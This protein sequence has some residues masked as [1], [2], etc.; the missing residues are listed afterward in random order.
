MI[1]FSNID[2][3]YKSLREE[4]LHVTDQVLTSGNVVDGDF[5][6][7]FE[8]WLA[9]KNHAKHAITCTSGTVALEIIAKYT[10]ELICNAINRSPTIIIP[11]ITYPATANAF[12]NAGWD[13][14]F[15]DVDQYGLIKPETIPT[16]SSHYMPYYM[17]VL[18]GLYGSSVECK[19]KGDDDLVIEDA[20]QHWLSNDCQR[21]GI[22]SAISFDPT[23]NFGNYGN[24]G[25]IVTN[26]GFLSEYAHAYRNNGKPT[27]NYIGSNLRMSEVDCAQL[28]IKSKYIDEW[29]QRRK[30]I[31]RYWMTEF[32][33]QGLNVLI[34]ENHFDKH[35][36]HKF[37]I[38]CN[39]RDN[40][41][42]KLHA[43]GIQTK[44]HYDTP[45]FKL[46]SFQHYPNPG[47]FST[48]DMLSK[49]VLSLPCYPEL[50]DSE[51]EYIAES[52]IKF[53]PSKKNNIYYD[54][55]KTRL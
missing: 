49:S 45:V 39:N 11:S 46:G 10:K 43:A 30:D 33:E 15:A 5:T 28:M 52:V 22:S 36:Y 47:M 44:V 32:K 6:K 53:N 29:Q 31:F 8:K 50:T 16:N 7:Q 12:A 42:K 9:A 27:N 40:M 38:S 21:C 48:A 55:V 37:V 51:I 25:A 18:V 20:A 4:I 2:R 34:D 23:K 3:Q 54:Y 13:L 17:T 24:G 26:D 1:P 41:A 19:N 14:C 35:S